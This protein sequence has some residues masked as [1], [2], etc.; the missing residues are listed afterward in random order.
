MNFDGF[1]LTSWLSTT[2]RPVKLKIKHGFLE[3]YFIDKQLRNTM[4]TL[5]AEVRYLVNRR[6]V[7]VSFKTH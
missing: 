4:A 7:G 2:Y 3:K 1:L 5:T 6:C